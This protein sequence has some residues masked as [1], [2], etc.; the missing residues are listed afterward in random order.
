VFDSTVHKRYKRDGSAPPEFA[1]II[2][3]ISVAG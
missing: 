1:M 2:R 3:E